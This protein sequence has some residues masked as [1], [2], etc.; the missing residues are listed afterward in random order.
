MVAFK[1]R[2]ASGAFSFVVEL[3]PPKG[4]DLSD[5]LEQAKGL[6]N[7]VGAIHVPDLPNGVM[8]LGSIATCAKLKE[9]G[10]ETIFE[11]SCSHRNRLALQSELLGASLL[12][13]EN[14]FLRQGESPAIGDHYEAK[15]VF[16]L[17]GIGLLEVAK[18]LEEGH[19]LMGNGLK[20]KP[21]F[22]VGSPIQIR[23][24]HR[25]FDVELREMERK[26]GLGAKFFVTTAIYDPRLFEAFLKRAASLHVPVLASLPLLKSAGMA[27]YMN[28]HVE[29]AVIPE[30]VIERL[31]KAPDKQKAS[32]QIA[33]ETIRELRALCQGVRLIPMGWESLIPLVLDQGGL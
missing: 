18:G 28:K 1:E 17:D 9:A 27:R 4:I 5:F 33:R 19:D 29:G 14:A 12:G 25:D 16:D 6:K 10:V 15:P 26:I 7:Q 31:M 3:Q 2:L 13:L 22:F 23:S 20:G 21:R 8:T 24:E 32:V 11:L 30:P